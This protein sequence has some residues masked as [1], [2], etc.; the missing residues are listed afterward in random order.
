MIYRWMN[1]FKPVMN[2][3][4]WTQTSATTWGHSRSLDGVLNEILHTYFR[5]SQNRELGQPC[6]DARNNNKKQS[7]FSGKKTAKSGGNL[8][9]AVQL[10]K[11]TPNLPKSIIPYSKNYVW[12][13]HE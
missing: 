1:I 6:K 10:P 12:I 4:C 13:H 2:W 5:E 3:F 11:T 8:V 9:E 7:K